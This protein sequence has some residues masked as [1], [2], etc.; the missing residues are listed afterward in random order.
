MKKGERKDGLGWK[1]VEVTEARSARDS[2]DILITPQP[3]HQ[4]QPPGFR[5][6]SYAYTTILNAMKASPARTEFTTSVQPEPDTEMLPL[7]LTEP[8]GKSTVTVR[9][10]APGDTTN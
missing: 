4:S 5:P 10:A 7:T 9:V 1:V 8:T 6:S 2:S 3:L